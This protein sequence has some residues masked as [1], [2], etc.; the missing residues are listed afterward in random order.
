MIIAGERNAGFPIATDK[1]HDD[2]NATIMKTLLLLL[3]LHL[4]S[5]TALL[6]ADTPAVEVYLIQKLKQKV[7]GDVQMGATILEISNPTEKTYY[8]HGLQIEFPFYETEVKRGE[9]WLL[10]SEFSCGTGSSFFPLKP[11]AKMLVTV[12]PRWD[13]PVSRFRFY[14]YTTDDEKT[15]KVVTVRSRA[16]ERKEL[17]DFDLSNKPV[18]EKNVELEEPRTD[19]EMNKPRE[20]DN[21]GDDPF[22]E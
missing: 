11:G 17:V 15:M 4:L 16:I 8:V 7:D 1:H 21:G 2:G 6:A 3:L 19:E 12:N 10:R 14:F 13:E 18:D 5:T 22:K 9:K 20:P